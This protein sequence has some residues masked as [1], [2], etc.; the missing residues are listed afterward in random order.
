MKKIIRL[1]ERDLSRIVNRVVK[2]NK[3]FKKDLDLKTKLDDIFFGQDEGNLFS[4]SGEFGYLS[5]ENRLK[6]KISPKQK[7]ERTQQVISDLEGYIQYLKS[8]RENEED[9]WIENPEYDSIWSSVDMGDSENEEV[10]KR[11]LEKRL[12][13]EESY[14][15]RYRRY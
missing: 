9:V 8:D 6:K 12:G 13:V 7:K 4:D 15:R 3:E 14:K 10:S 1:T 2:E 11:D 5:Q